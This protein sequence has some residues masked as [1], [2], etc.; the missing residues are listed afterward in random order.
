MRSGI[1]PVTLDDFLLDEH[2]V[3]VADYRRCMAAG[4][5]ARPYIPK[6]KCNV[7]R[8][9]EEDH[10]V[11]CLRFGMLVDYCK[12]ARGRVP[13][14]AEWEWAARGR[15]NG[16]RHPWGSSTPAPGPVCW[17]HLGSCKVKSSAG[18]VTVDGVYDMAGN[19]WEWT[20]DWNG[21]TYRS[22]GTTLFA[23]ESGTADSHIVQPI[24]S[25]Y[26]FRHVG[27]RCAADL[28]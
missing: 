6:M 1:G 21:Q 5:C 7:D 20:V 26:D 16:F 8:T 22:G 23:W 17:K 9:G 28:K 4:A 25:V 10:P 11:G 18:D 14:N 19:L 13:L 12:W 15:E 27:G 2:E 3:T 24:V